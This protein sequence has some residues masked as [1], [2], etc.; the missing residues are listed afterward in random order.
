MNVTVCNLTRFGDL[1]Q[2][3]AVI[4]DLAA[5]GHQV[6][7]VCLD[8]FAAA[9]ALI[10]NVRQT[11]ALP[12]A[13]LI[14]RTE[15]AW[16][17]AVCQVAAF[18]RDLA[19]LAKPECVFNL[20][21]GAP[22]RL[23]ARFLTPAGARNLGFDLDNFGFGV[24]HGVWA[25]FFS[26]AARKRVNSPF[27]LADM[28]RMMATPL[29]GGD[30]SGSF[31]LAQPDSASIEWARAFLA[32]PGI[33][34][35]GHIAFQLGASEER[36]RWPVKNF[37]ALGQTLWDERRLIPVLLGSASEKRLAAEYALN[38]GHPFID[39]TGSTDIPRL[40]GLLWH[41]RLLVTNDTGTMHL[42]SGLGIPSLAFFF[43]TAQP[44][45]TGPMLPGCCCLEPALEC[46]PCAFGRQCG[47]GENCRSHISATTAA[48]LVLGWLENGRWHADN[49]TDARVWLTG[50]GADSL[51]Q[52]K[53]ISQTAC[54]GRSLWL[55]WMRVFWRQ[56]F[57]YME[58]LIRRREDI[59]EG[60]QEL[61]VP[62]NAGA[63]AAGLAEGAKLLGIIADCGAEMAAA[64]RLAPIFLRN[65]ERL[66]A[67]WENVPE[68]EAIAAFWDEFRKNHG[69]DMHLFGRR[70]R[71]MA[72]H[73]HGL[74]AAIHKKQAR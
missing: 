64:P 41:M 42:A 9:S 1:L 58:G 4:D 68:L 12:G 56:L 51:Y 7:L 30:L 33:P 55:A 71:I 43:A 47:H 60:Y 26:V 27:N 14:A 49:I 52:I 13:K 37:Q 15:A 31:R 11:W 46:H 65:C 2:S 59:A 54:A 48:G 19:E 22:A 6:D 70:A 36:R 28:L 29:T 44:W 66:Q 62:D 5:A 25:S 50:R 57:D 61:A 8:N 18:Q 32:E 17:E 24:D 40:G 45:D 38:A 35:S 34:R 67:F 53:P 39:A 16:P 20:T 69:G 72:E 73:V 21:P 10:R 23:L 63:I 74:A 3:Q